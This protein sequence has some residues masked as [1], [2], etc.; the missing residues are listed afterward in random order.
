M[1]GHGTQREVG[2]GKI[3]IRRNGEKYLPTW[4]KCDR[5]SY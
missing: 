2:D 3:R 5:V 4:T 1:A